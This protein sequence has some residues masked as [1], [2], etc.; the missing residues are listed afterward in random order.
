MISLKNLASSLTVLELAGHAECKFEGVWLKIRMHGA[1]PPISD[2]DA[3]RLLRYGWQ[4]FNDT[5]EWWFRL[6]G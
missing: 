5:N 6:N 1:S 2:E 3:G 4:F